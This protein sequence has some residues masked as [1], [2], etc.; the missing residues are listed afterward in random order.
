MAD[1]DA[2]GFEFEV[3]I[4]AEAVRAGLKLAWV[5][6]ATIYNTGKVSYFHPVKTRPDSSQRSG[7]RGACPCRTGGEGAIPPR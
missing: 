3:D 4:I 5:D 6:V 2:V 7:V 1:K